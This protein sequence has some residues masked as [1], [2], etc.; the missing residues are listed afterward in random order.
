MIESK[1]KQR[2]KLNRLIA[3]KIEKSL[4]I[5]LSDDYDIVI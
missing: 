5:S 3:E 1:D 2:T 4:D